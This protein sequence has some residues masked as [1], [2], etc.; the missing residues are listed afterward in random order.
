M[1]NQTAKHLSQSDIAIQIE[2]L[3]NA[4]IRH[5][6]PAFR[7]SYDAQ[8][9]E[10]IERTRLSRY[11]DHIRQMYY[12]VNDDAYALN[13]HLI[14][15]R[16]ACH[17]IGL[18]FGMAGMTCLSAS[19]DRYLSE[20]ETLNWLVEQIS[21]QV[22]TKRFQR[23]KHDRTYRE[24][25]NRQ[26]VT[27]YVER[28]LG[29]RSRTLVVRVD[30]YYREAARARLKVEDVFE[31]LDRLI[32]AREYDPVFQ[33]ETG[34]ICAVEQGEDMGYHLHAAFFFDGREVL[35]DISKAKAIGKLWERIT[36]G[37]GYFHSCNHEKARYEERCGVGMF[38]RDDVV[39]RQNVIN[40]CHYLIEDGQ[41]LRV[42]PVG[43]R[44]LR[45]GRVHRGY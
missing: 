1:T 41:A 23:G 25:Q 14:A 12:L 32:R 45:I 2:R 42:K 13:E 36:D 16:D 43:A 4:V 19:E 17:D 22:R 33:H 35:M 24:K 26:T 30:L 39:G 28:V 31:D 20:A 9:D 37:W 11:F 7:I 29:S 5:D 40:A 38:K 8:G 27:D 34:Y 10:V 44:A 18:E 6:S 3:V 15:F 21:V